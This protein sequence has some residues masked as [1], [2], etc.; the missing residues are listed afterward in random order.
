VISERADFDEHYFPGLKKDLL[1]AVPNNNY[2]PSAPPQIVQMPELGGDDEPSNALAPPAPVHIPDPPEV[3][4]E[5]DNDIPDIPD[6]Y[7]VAP[8]APAPPQP[9]PEPVP[10]LPRRSNRPRNPPGEWWKIRHPPPQIDD[11]D[12]E[13][14]FTV[15]DIDPDLESEEFAGISAGTDPRTYKQAMNSPDVLHWKKAMLE[16]INALLKNGTWE[17]VRLPDGEKAIGSGWVFK[18]KR[19]AD[20]SI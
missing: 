13:L 1:V 20:G 12:D 14:G 19:N 18:I 9:V 17:I 2:P 7:D 15:I 5:E 10:N 4:N 3:Q 8:V 11:S 16:E 6:V